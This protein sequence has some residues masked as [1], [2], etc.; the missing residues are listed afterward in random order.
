MKFYFWIW[1]KSFSL[2]FW[3]RGWLVY[4]KDQADR[5]NTYFWVCRLGDAISRAKKR[6]ARII[7][8]A[9]LRYCSKNKRWR[10]SEA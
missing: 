1:M 2:A 6:W 7:F 5:E 9:S 4:W 8:T 10:F 3:E